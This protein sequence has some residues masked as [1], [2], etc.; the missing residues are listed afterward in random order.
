MHSI[1]QLIKEVK[2]LNVGIC[3][4]APSAALSCLFYFDHGYLYVC[5]VQ[6]KFQ[7]SAIELKVKVKYVYNLFEC[8]SFIF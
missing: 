4:G 2:N 6:R 3:D 1:V 8:P 7:I 5:K